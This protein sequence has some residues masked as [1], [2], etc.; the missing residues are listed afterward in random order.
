MP[1]TH[2]QWEKPLP[3]TLDLFEKLVPKEAERRQ[4]FGFP[5]AFVQGHMFM[6]VHQ[7]RIALRLSEATRTRLVSSKQAAPV[8]PSG[9][10]MREYVMLDHKIEQDRDKALALVEESFA[11]VAAQPPKEKK[12][13]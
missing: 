4:M 2:A 8:D 6:W 3:E 1:N 10:R 12:A 9:R 11:Y 5:C 13:R 7:N